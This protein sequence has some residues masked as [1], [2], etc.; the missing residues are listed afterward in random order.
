MEYIPKG[1]MC[2]SCKHLRE[3][4]SDLPFHTMRMAKQHPDGVMEV[5]CTKFK[6]ADKRM[7]GET[8][9]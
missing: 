1:S 4:C 7:D 3:D 9:K 2:M 5:I 6:R 8:H